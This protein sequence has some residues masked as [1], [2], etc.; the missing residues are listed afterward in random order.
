MPRAGN[1]A[2]SKHMS[3]HPFIRSYAMVYYRDPMPHLPPTFLGY[4][5]ATKFY[6]WLYRTTGGDSRTTQIRTAGYRSVEKHVPDPFYYLDS[7][8]GSGDMDAYLANK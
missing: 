8:D 5:Q 6:S 7:L 3:T 4:R 1:K 2:L